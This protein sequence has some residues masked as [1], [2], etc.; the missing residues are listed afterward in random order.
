MFFLRKQFYKS[1]SEKWR[2]AACT[3]MG[4]CFQ[5]G[6]YGVRVFEDARGHPFMNAGYTV[7]LYPLGKLWMTG[8]ILT[9]NLNSKVLII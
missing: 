5:S 7:T 3:D 4:L 2:Y 1:S 9:W 6:R 8:A